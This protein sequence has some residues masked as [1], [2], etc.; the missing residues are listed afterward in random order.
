VAAR[1]NEIAK[2]ELAM[3]EIHCVVR[4]FT[5]SVGDEVGTS[6]KQGITIWEPWQ[7]H[8]SRYFLVCCWSVWPWDC[9]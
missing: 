6:P 3:D 2:A 9:T 1:T 4:P 8:T 7:P 5:F